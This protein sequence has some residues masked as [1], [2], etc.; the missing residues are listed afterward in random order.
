M[1][2]ALKLPK[3]LLSSLRPGDVRLYLTSRGWIGEPFGKGGKGLR[4]HHPSTQQVDLLLPLDRDLGDYT[5]R[6]AEL[7]TSLATIESRPWSQIIRDLSGPAGDVF[8]FR[9][10]AADATLGNLPLDQGIALLRGG[11]D[12]LLAASCS[13][14]HPRPL[15]PQGLHKKVLEFLKTCR[16][17]QTEQGSFVATIITP[18]PP[19][20]QK[21]MDFVDQGFRLGL[22]PF[23]RRVTTRLMSTLAFVSDA[24]QTGNPGQILEGIDQG[25]SANFCDALKAMKPSGDQSRLE[26]SVTWAATRGHVPETVPKSVSFPQDTFSFIEEAGRE[27]RIRAFAKPERYRGRLIT[28][29]LINRPFTREPVGRIVM[30]TE[31]AGQPAK[32]K[33]DLAP[34]D[35]RRA[36][37]ALRDGI[38]KPV[39]VTGIIRNDVKTRLYELTEASDFEVIE[40]D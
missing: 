3:D 32:V 4:F 1:T 6:M 34:E 13:V 8:R 21:V 12:L 23:P 29:E 19:E 39:A 36:C 25:V 30:A 5:A 10:D 9:V 37:D 17:G 14:L 38:P 11:R 31:V 16:L 33:V 18:V 7:V 28:T 2:S 27:L 35:F 15:H 20:I 22:E 26:I 24:I 40:Y